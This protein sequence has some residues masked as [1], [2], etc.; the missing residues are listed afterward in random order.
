MGFFDFLKAKPDQ[1][2]WWLKEKDPRARRAH[3]WG[4]SKFVEKQAGNLRAVGR[5]DDAHK[6]IAEFLTKVFQEFKNE[7]DNP[8]HLSFLTDIALRL[9]ALEVGKKTLE[10]V[11]ESDDNLSLDLTLVY[12]S[13]GRIYHQLRTDRKRELWCYEM[14]V[15]A[16]SPPNCKFPATRQQKAIAHRFAFSLLRAWSYTWEFEMK[17]R[18]A[19]AEDIA[20][21]REEHRTDEQRATTHMQKAKELVPEVNWDDP[22]YVHKLMQ[23]E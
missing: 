22:D 4:A 6:V 3:L 7:P 2:D 9:G 19:G 16:M 12:E 13:L 21:A 1:P 20:R 8:R 11:I 5:K 14:A 17:K 10:S 18:G 15:G 23:S